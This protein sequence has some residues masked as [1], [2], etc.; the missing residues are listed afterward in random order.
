MVNAP[1][2]KGP[3]TY[4]SFKLSLMYLENGK[5]FAYATYP[6]DTTKGSK[7]HGTIFECC[8]LSDD[9]EDGD[10]DTSCSHSSNCTTKDEELDRVGDTAK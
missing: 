2:I 9:G 5:N 10:E 6:K 4:R 1:P 8:D 7:E 3:I